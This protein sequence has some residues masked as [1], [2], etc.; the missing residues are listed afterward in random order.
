MLTK[1]NFVCKYIIVKYL[2]LLTNN[3]KAIYKR[4][5]IN[6]IYKKFRLSVIY[7]RLCIKVIYE[8]FRKKSFMKI[9]YKNL[10]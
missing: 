3:A 10:L 6:G 7:E 1:T 9:S 5:R 2:I 4:F 8:R